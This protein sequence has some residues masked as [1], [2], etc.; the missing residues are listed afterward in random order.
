MLGATG[1][2]QERVGPGVEVI[3]DRTRV[4]DEAAD[5]LPQLRPARLGG[6]SGPNA[7]RRQPIREVAGGDVRTLDVPKYLFRTLIVDDNGTN[8]VVLQEL[9]QRWGIPNVSV[10]NAE[11]ALCAVD[12]AENANEPFGIPSWTMASMRP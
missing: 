5:L 8:R 9:L 3:G 2:E 6:H 7:L 4:E 10:D 12:Q 1:R 11:A